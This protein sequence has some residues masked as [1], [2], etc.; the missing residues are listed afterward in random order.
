LQDVRLYSDYLKFIN[1]E[2][3]KYILTLNEVCKYIDSGKTKM[4]SDEEKLKNK[5]KL[6]G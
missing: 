2:K 4:F 5:S 3:V 6:G 1:R